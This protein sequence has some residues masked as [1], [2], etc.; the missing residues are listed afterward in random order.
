MSDNSVKDGLI[1]CEPCGDEFI[2]KDIPIK[3]NKRL[4]NVLEG[5]G[6]LLF[7]KAISVEKHVLCNVLCAM[8]NA[9]STYTGIQF[10]LTAEY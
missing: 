5:F 7:F 4:K 2:V 8:H 9:H 6:R 10:V 1:K 3:E